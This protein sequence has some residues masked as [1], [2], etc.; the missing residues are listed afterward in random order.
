MKATN[1]LQAYSILITDDDERQR[2]TLREIVEPEGYRTL[3]ASSGEEALD[4]VQQESIHLVLLDMHMPSLNGLDTLRLVHQIREA[5]PCILVTG[6]TSDVLMRQAFQAHA[7]SVI[8]KPVSRP[9]VLHTVVRALMRFY[10]S[11]RNP[12]RTP[13]APDPEAG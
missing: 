9:V 2:D 1:D 7:Y 11:L 5:L 13:P 3:L 10:N 8:H 12:D 4:I 6:D